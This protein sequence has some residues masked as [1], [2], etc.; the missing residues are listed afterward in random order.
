[1]LIKIFG[2]LALLILFTGCINYINLSTSQINLRLREVSIKKIIGAQK[3]HL[4]QQFF[5]ETFLVLTIALLLTTALLLFLAPVFNRLSGIDF[6]RAIFSWKT[7]GLLLGVFGLTL[8][9]SGIYPALLLASLKPLNVFRG[10][11]LPGLKT[12]MLRKILVVAQFTFTVILVSAAIV[13][14]NQMKYMRSQQTG[15]NTDQVLT[16]PIPL[17]VFQSYSK[18]SRTG[19]YSSLKNEWKKV[20]GVHAVTF[21]SEKIIDVQNNSQSVLK[22]AGQDPGFSPMV[23]MLSVDED[24]RN[25]FGI[26]IKEGRWIEHARQDDI[27]N[28]LL[29]ESAVDYLGIK[30]PIGKEIEFMGKPGRIIGIVKNFH[31]RS[32]REKTGPLVLYMSPSWAAFAFIKMNAPNFGEKLPP[33]KNAWQNFLPNVPFDY[34]FLDESFDILYKQDLQ[35]SEIVLLFSLL[36]VFI[37]AIGLFGLLL[38]STRRRIREFAIRKTLGANPIDIAG[39]LSREFLSLVIIAALIGIPV[40]WFLTDQWLNNF[41]YRISMSLM[42]FIYAGFLTILLAFFIISCQAII[43]FLKNPA[44]VLRSDR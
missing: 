41:A 43:S 12:A 37:A 20:P 21:C 14:Y 38:F 10:Q 40:G 44:I 36:S 35:T 18:E 39:L 30:D 42:N 5:L 22:W 16:L 27:K 15:Y 32:L 25:V 28:I 33:I 17:T 1:M 19:I 4:F 26:E 24:T 29:N 23:S 34:S 7:W 13:I 8:L 3:K 11:T 31:Y 6:L 9:L 2:S